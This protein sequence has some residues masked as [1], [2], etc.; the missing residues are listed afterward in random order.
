MAHR[1][2]NMWSRVASRLTA[3]AHTRAGAFRWGVF[4]VNWTSQADPFGSANV[5]ALIT[6]DIAR[7][8]L[9]RRPYAAN[10]ITPTQ[11]TPLGTVDLTNA[12]N[13]FTLPVTV[14]QLSCI[15]LAFH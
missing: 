11:V 10:L 8:G 5:S 13:T 9:D 3:I 2:A 12:P 15:Y 14:D 7:M 4:V 1:Y 6:F